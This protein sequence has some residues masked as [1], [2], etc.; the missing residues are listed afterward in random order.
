MVSVCLSGPLYSPISSFQAAGGSAGARK[1]RE[2]GVCATDVAIAAGRTDAVRT[3]K[4]A[5][6]ARRLC[7]PG[8]LFGCTVVNTFAIEAK[9]KT[10][11]CGHFDG[12][13]WRDVNG[14]I[15][16]VVLP[17]TPAG[18]NIARQRVA[19]QRRNS[20][21]VGPADS[22]FQHAA[23]PSRDLA[24]E[25]AGL[26]IAGA[27]MPADAPKFDVDDARSAHFNSSHSMA[28]VVDR[29]VETN[30]SLQLF[31]EFSVCGD[32]IPP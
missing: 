9:A 30:G 14:R 15:D 32:V 21:I 13:L 2:G 10:R 12:A 26:R 11:H 29:F 27:G 23:T 6:S 24:C 16:D 4:A 3:V 8:F 28:R 25:T 1:P 22:G 5:D 19:R 20:D 31:L 17:V 18:G 7:T